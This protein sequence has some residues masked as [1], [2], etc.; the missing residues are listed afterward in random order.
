[1]S[2]DSVREPAHRMAVDADGLERTQTPAP[3][4]TPAIDR[5]ARTS[6]RMYQ[7]LSASSAGLE[8]G[9]SVGIGALFGAWLDGEFGTEPW[10]LLV[11]MLVGVIAGFRGLLRAVARADRA[12]AAEQ[13]ERAN[14]GG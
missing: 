8:L 6:K 10:M 5:A 2:Q 9:I 4:L 12:A 7:G 14:S 1:M 3:K 11:F 13:A